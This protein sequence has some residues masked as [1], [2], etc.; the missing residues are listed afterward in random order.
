[1]LPYGH[2]ASVYVLL[3]EC[4]SVTIYRLPE[5]S[6][7]AT[8]RVSVMF[9]PSQEVL[10]Y[11]E[12]LRAEFPNAQLKASRL[13]DFFDAAQALSD[14]LPVVTS[15]FGDTWIQGVASDPRKCA[16]YRAVSRVMRRCLA[17]GMET[18]LF[19]L[20]KSQRKGV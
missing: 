7:L 12:I 18:I 14:R 20:L 6:C 16:E 15:E 11:Y 10:G 9:C 17:A 3:V 2:Y 13:D 8:H 4:L 5:C 19:S 1:M